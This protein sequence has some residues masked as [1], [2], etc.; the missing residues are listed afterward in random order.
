MQWTRSATLNYVLLAIVA[1]ALLAAW[2]VLRRDEPTD[3]ER[4]IEDRQAILDSGELSVE[5]K[6][7][8]GSVG[9][10]FLLLD[11]QTWIW[12]R[13][14][15][16]GQTLLHDSGSMRL[17]IEPGCFIEIPPETR[18]LIPGITLTRSPADMV[19]PEVL[20]PKELRYGAFHIREPGN[21]SRVQV[22]ERI[23]VE[24]SRITATIGLGHG[25]APGTFTI[26]PMSPS[27][28]ELA[29]E[30]LNTPASEVAILDVRTRMVRGPWKD[31]WDRNP[32]VVAENCPA[33]LIVARANGTTV[34][35]T[36]A[37][38]EPM[39]LVFVDGCAT[40]TDVVS[41][42]VTSWGHAQT[43]VADLDRRDGAQVGAPLQT[44]ATFMTHEAING[45]RRAFYIEACPEDSWL[46]CCAS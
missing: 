40:V 5:F 21:L 4:L 45:V 35:Q 16:W 36:Y 23:E 38:R 13:G 46:T 42:G 27:E 26:Q 41:F 43:L 31:P 17:Q 28:L 32:V 30:Q 6:P 24:A 11:D 34:R 18:P 20:A 29:R 33:P 1:A 39:N 8:G 7:D 37:H 12:D 10:R 3:L 22:T 15:Y 25:F 19:E 9:W 44:G 2:L 14:P